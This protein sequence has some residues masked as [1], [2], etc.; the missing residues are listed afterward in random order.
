[1][2]GDGDHQMLEVNERDF[3]IN[4]IQSEF[5]PLTSLP[6]DDLHSFEPISAEPDADGE[7]FVVL[8]HRDDNSTQ[9]YRLSRPDHLVLNT[10]YPDEIIKFYSKLG[11]T[12]KKFGVSYH[13]PLILLSLL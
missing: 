10:E 7:S 4:D 12:P 11:M 1:M 3:A 5:A 8:P 6:S 2:R 13:Y 9:S